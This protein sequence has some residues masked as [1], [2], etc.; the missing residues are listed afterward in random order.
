MEIQS[1]GSAHQCCVRNITGSLISAASPTFNNGNVG[2]V[3]R[4][5]DG[6]FATFAVLQ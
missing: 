5:V 3:T 6:S 1:V 2:V 4:T